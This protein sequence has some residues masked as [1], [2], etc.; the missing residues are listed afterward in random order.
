[1]LTDEPSVIL[2]NENDKPIGSEKKQAAHEKG[3]LHRAFSVFVL[4]EQNKQLQLLLQ[5]RN[6]KKYHCGGLWT[7]T[8]CSHPIPGETTP[9]AASRRLQ[10]ELGFTTPL[11]HL[12]AFIYKAAF[13]NGL[14]EHEY[15]HVFI[16][17]YQNQPITP[18]SDEV[19]SIIWVNLDTLHTQISQNPSQYTPWLLPALEIVTNV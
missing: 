12:G 2:V 8:C 10:E 4:R 9:N 14:T 3:L 1:M 15:D 7:N 16:G 17:Y 11:T 6:P 18:N 13:A 5:Q 19:S